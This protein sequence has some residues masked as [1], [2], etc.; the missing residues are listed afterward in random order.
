MRSKFD[1]NKHVFPELHVY[2]NEGSC[3]HFTAKSQKFRCLETHSNPPER[4]ETGKDQLCVVFPPDTA[5]ETFH[6]P[7]TA[8][9]L[10]KTLT[11]LQSVCPGTNTDETTTRRMW[12]VLRQVVNPERSVGRVVIP[13][14]RYSVKTNFGVV[15]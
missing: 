14:S 1:M 12:R 15:E 6:F 4:S 9:S 7:E 2:E 5:A 10:V 13:I 8:T 3:G 11:L